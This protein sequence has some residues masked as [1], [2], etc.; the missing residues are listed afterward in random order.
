MPN[1]LQI[2]SSQN[3]RFKALL[4][5]RTSKH[6][7][8]TGL[9]LID[10]EVEIARAI[11]SGIEIQSILGLHSSAQLSLDFSEKIGEFLTLSEG[12]MAKL[13]YGER[14]QQLIAV[15]SIPSRSLSEIK[16]DREPLVLVL[17][18]LEKP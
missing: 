12:L 8:R 16:L 5:L 2:T 6:R 18:Q 9:F 15:A 17:D 3:P 1:V 11:A 10:G 14:T 4:Q 7:R 13:A